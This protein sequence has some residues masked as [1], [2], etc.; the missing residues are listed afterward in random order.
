MNVIFM[1]WGKK[2]SA[3]DVNRLHSMVSSCMKVN[4]DLYAS[5]KIA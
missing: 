3:E 2:F 1:K 5:Q 4:L